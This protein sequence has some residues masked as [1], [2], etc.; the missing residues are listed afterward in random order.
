MGRP[1]RSR[2]SSGSSRS[3][4]GVGHPDDLPGRLGRRRITDQVE[5]FPGR[6]GAGKIFHTQVRASGSIP[7]VCAL[8]RPVSGGRRLHPGLLR[9]RADGGRERLDVPGQP[10]D[11]RRWWSRSR[12]RS[13]RWAAPG[14]TAPSPAAA[15]TSPRSEARR[16]RRGPLLPVLPAGQLAAAAAGRACPRRQAGR[17]A[18]ARARSASGRPTTCAGYVARAGRRRTRCSRSTRCGQG[19]RGRLRPARWRG[20]RR[21]GNNRCSRAACCS[22]TPRTRPPGSSSSA[23]RST[24][25]CSSSPTSPDSWWAPPLKG[26]ASSGTAPR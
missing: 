15:T 7:Q 11:G 20:H 23:T 5:M 25:R 1:H 10:A 8:V 6:R 12:P 24:C 3:A 13:R 18:R 16:D 21:R 19:T 2:R 22:S 4:Y 14:C 9:L 26:R 17:P